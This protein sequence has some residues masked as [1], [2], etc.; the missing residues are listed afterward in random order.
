MNQLPLMPGRKVAYR[1]RGSAAGD[2]D[3]EDG[4]DGGH[5]TRSASGGAKEPEAAETG[6]I[7]ATVKGMVNGDKTRY[8]VIDADPEAQ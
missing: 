4:G 3:S 6:W 5:G 7:L 2:I 1:Q 8:E